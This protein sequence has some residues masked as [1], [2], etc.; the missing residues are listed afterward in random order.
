MRR[1][2]TGDWGRQGLVGSRVR[3]YPQIGGGAGK[4]RGGRNRS[5]DLVGTIDR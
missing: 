5:F 3:P 4:A 1:W 2:E